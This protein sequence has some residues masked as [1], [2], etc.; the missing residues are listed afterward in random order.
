M[1]EELLVWFYFLIKFCYLI[2]NKKS[3][4]FS[5]STII[6]HYEY[7]FMQSFRSGVPQCSIEYNFPLKIKFFSL[8]VAQLLQKLHMVSYY[9][10]NKKICDFLWSTMCSATE[11]LLSYSSTNWKVF[12]F[13]WS[14]LVLLYEYSTQLFRSGAHCA[15][16]K[17]Y[18]LLQNK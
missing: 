18:F 13:L 11:R 5:W 4:V 6:S 16:F 14:T 3:Q 7:I 17:Y 8:G 1:I 2:G 12:D 10:T 9:R 15:P